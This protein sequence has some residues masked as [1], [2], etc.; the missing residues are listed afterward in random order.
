MQLV[1]HKK[2]VLQEPVLAHYKL[3]VFNLLSAGPDLHF[4]I[5]GGKNF[6]GIRGIDDDRFK[7]FS[8]LGFRIAG[9]RFY[10]LK[11]SVRYILSEKPDAIICTGVDFHQIH[12]LLLFFI[13]RILLRKKFFWWSHATAGKQGVAGRMA[14]K[15]FY[16]NA[17]GILAYSHKGKSTLEKMGIQQGNICVVNNSLNSP[18]YGFLNTDI[19]KPPFKD[20]VR[21]IFCGRIIPSKRLDLLIAALDHIHRHEGMNFE[22]VIVGGGDAN[23][24][25]SEVARL[26]LNDKIR[27]TGALYGEPLREY[28]LHSDLMVYPGGIG[29]SIVQAFSY[30]IPV[31]TTGNENLQ[32]PEIELLEPGINGDFYEDGSVLDLASKIVLW[33]RKLEVSRN[34]IVEA[35]VRSIREKGYLPEIVAGNTLRFLRE[36]MNT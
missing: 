34:A 10:F 16:K 28:L 36:K 14:R 33:K 26:G 7:T 19:S 11:G 9:H 15:F 23:S 21:I 17:T 22:C 24:M 31:I 3:D 8:F 20:P 5:V 6:E 13:H 2:I 4:I 12:Q 32:M 27:F 29:L 1:D 18:D 25:I 30:G 35:C